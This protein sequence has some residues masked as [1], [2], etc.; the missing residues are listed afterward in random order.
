MSDMVT[1]VPNGTSSHSRTPSAVSVATTVEHDTPTGLQHHNHIGGGGHARST[2][3]GSM[4]VASNATSNADGRNSLALDSLASE[5]ETL[6]SHWETTNKNYRLS[7]RFDFENQRGVGP[8]RTTESL[9]NWRKGL[10][11]D[12]EDENSRPSTAH[13]PSMAQSSAGKL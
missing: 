6:R 8:A 1:P 12:E 3:L 13:G 7:E 4:S 5:L 9:A 11:I 2:S 10:D